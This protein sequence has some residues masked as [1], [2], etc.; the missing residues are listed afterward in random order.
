MRNLFPQNLPFTLIIVVLAMLG[1]SC[2]T[3]SRYIEEGLDKVIKQ[4]REVSNFTVLL[5]DMDYAQGKYLHQYQ[6]LTMEPDSTFEENTTDWLEVSPRFFK[7][8]QDHL[9]MELA[10]KENGKLEKETAPAGYSQ[11]V[12]N[13]Q[14]GRWVDRG[15]SSFWEFYGKYAMLNAIFNMGGRPARYS[16]WDTYNRD[17]R[18]RGSVYY[19]PSRYYGTTSYVNNTN[20]GKQSAWG[21]KPSSFK[22]SVRN[23]VSRSSSTSSRTSRS[24]S[25]YSGSSTRSRSRGGFG[26]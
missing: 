10:S 23:R 26:K 12:G 16:Y 15:G 14:Y 25:R 9:G 4:N 17:Y 11:Y 5:Y 22:Q 7:A 19:G 3:Q 13:P 2:S 21:K 8:H 24:S 6:V 18:G 1:S 20:K